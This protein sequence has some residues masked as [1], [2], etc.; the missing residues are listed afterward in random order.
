VGVRK[1]GRADGVFRNQT[2]GADAQGWWWVAGQE[3]GRRQ[4]EDEEPPTSRLIKYERW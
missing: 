2:C 4:G 1:N 3:E